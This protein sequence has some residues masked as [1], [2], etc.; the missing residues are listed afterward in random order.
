MYT[1][2]LIKICCMFAQFY[3]QSGYA[4]PQT[5]SACLNSCV[6]RVLCFYS[7][8]YTLYVDLFSWK[9]NLFYN[10]LFI[11]IYRIKSAID[12]RPLNAPLSWHVLR[13]LGNRHPQDVLSA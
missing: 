9:S 11:Y 12:L 8:S 7:Y 6:S 13:L 5:V 1:H 4:D 3:A 10:H 2:T